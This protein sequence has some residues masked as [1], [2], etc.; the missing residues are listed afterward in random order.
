MSDENSTMADDHPAQLGRNPAELMENSAGENAA[1]TRPL[2]NPGELLQDIV[3]FLHRLF[4]GHGAP[5][6]PRDAD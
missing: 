2:K 5:G 3:D 6:A 1:E 4:P